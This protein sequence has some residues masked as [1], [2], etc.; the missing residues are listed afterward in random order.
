MWYKLLP[1]Q[2]V[3]LV[4]L[5]HASR[6]VMHTASGWLTSLNEAATLP[7][8]LLLQGFDPNVGLF[9]ST[10]DNRLYP[11]PEA[12]ALVP[13]A[14]Q[15]FEFLGRMLGKVCVSSGL[16][17]IACLLT[18]SALLHK[19]LCTMAQNAACRRVVLS[20]DACGVQAASPTPIRHVLADHAMCRLPLG[21]MPKPHR[22]AT[23]ASPGILEPYPRV[24]AMPQR[25]PAR[26]PPLLMSRAQS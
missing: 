2:H 19:V 5:N 15:L 3:W 16:H 9:A 20:A 10:S 1:S 13:E 22:L 26:A 25:H 12:P 23:S 4:R 24:Q 17:D 11:N 14:L 18:R 6:I 7:N 21:P 8:V